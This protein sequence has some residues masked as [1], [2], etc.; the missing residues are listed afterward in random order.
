MY[1][2]GCFVVS[3]RQSNNVQ[4]IQ[5]AFDRNKLGFSE[6]MSSGRWYTFIYIFLQCIFTD[7]RH[8]YKKRTIS[9]YTKYWYFIHNLTSWNVC[10]LLKCAFEE[11]NE[12]NITKK[13]LKIE[14]GA[15][16]VKFAGIFVNLKESRKFRWTNFGLNNATFH[17]ETQSRTHLT[18]LF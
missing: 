7:N 4:N 9:K 13:H 8:T 2:F 18:N 12:Q 10:E 15:K 17:L 11:K 5:Y 16:S 6:A 3:S 1:L 14:V